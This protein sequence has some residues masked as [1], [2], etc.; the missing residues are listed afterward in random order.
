MFVVVFVGGQ[1]DRAI[2]T[3]DNGKHTRT[4]GR[5]ERE[6]FWGGKGNIIGESKE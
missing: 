6:P 1:V 2:M 3:V 4:E 5:N